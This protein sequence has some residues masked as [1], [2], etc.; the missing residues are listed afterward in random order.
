VLLV[1]ASFCDPEKFCTL[2]DH[3]HQYDGSHT[4]S[5]HHRGVGRV[6]SPFDL[7]MVSRGTGDLCDL[8]DLLSHRC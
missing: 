2:S 1:V 4:T 6:S 8:S 5:L 7:R 3:V